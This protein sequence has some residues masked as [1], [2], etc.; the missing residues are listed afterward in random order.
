MPWL[1]QRTAPYRGAF[2]RPVAH[3]WSRAASGESER[4]CAQRVTA[5]TGLLAVQFSSEAEAVWRL[6]DAGVPY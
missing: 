1:T 5:L 2:A 6:Q 3:Q 4:P